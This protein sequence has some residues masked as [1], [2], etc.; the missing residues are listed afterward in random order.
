M[1]PFTPNFEGAYHIR[2]WLTFVDETLANESGMSDDGPP[3]RKIAIAAIIRNPLAGRFEEDLSPIIDPSPGLGKAFAARFAALL[4]E[5]EAPQSHG[6]AA[7]AGTHGECE[8]GKAFLTTAFANEIRDAFG[9]CAWVPSTIKRGGPGTAIDVPLACN[10][11]LYVRS[12]YDTITVTIP[13]GPGPDEVVVIFA[14]AT[15]GRIHAR[16]GGV[17]HANREGD[18][19]R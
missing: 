9:A 11:A 15:R 8:H 10:D 5:G 14:I 13:D 6:K 2:K 16:L 7:I 1:D 12:H 3:L 17:A 4:P 19:L 18:G